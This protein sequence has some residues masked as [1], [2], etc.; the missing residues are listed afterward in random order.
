MDFLGKGL[1][2]KYADDK[3]KKDQEL[4]KKFG[5]AANIVGFFNPIIGIAFTGA[6]AAQ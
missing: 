6:G 3:E 4:K 1:D 5:W 2:K